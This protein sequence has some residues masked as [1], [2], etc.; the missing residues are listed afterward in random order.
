MR[1]KERIGKERKWSV[2]S[3]DTGEK[4]SRLNCPPAFVFSLLAG[5]L[6]GEEAVGFEHEYDS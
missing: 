6:R 3:E 1:Q 5:V 4:L 2:M